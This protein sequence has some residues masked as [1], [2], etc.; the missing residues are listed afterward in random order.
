VISSNAPPSFLTSSKRHPN[1]FYLLE[2][3]TDFFQFDVLFFSNFKSIPREQFIS[4]RVKYLQLK[5]YFVVFWILK[6]LKEVVVKVKMVFDV[7][8]I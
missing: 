3:V 7:D 6:G 1:R 5:F 4:A 2:K 8:A